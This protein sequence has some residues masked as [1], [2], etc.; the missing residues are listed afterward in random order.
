MNLRW[1][2]FHATYITLC[3]KALVLIFM[4]HKRQISLLTSVFKHAGKLSNY[5]VPG[6]YVHSD[7][8]NLM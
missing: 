1:R 4:E 6:G 7:A 3:D 8:C 5:V 2:L